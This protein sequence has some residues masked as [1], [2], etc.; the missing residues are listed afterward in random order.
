VTIT[1]ADGV[2]GAGGIRGLAIAGALLELQEGNDR[3]RISEW[4][5]L[6]GT[7]AG[8]IVA[9]YLAAGK[10][11]S[12]LVEL[13]PEIPRPDY[14]R[15]GMVMGGAWNLVRHRGLARG[16]RFQK[17][18]DGKLDGLEFG[19]LRVDGEYRL[20]MVAADITNRRIV[21]IPDDLGRYRRPGAKGP[22]DRDT[23]PVAFG[24]RM[25]MAIPYL[26]NPVELV[27]GDG[28]V[29]TIVD[30][31]VISGF[32]VWLFDV[33]HRDLLRPTFGV[34]IA[35]R[36]ARARRGIGW[37]VG[38]ARDIYSTGSGAWDAHFVADSS[39]LRTC[40]VPTGDIPG[41]RFNAPQADRDDLVRAGRDAM[42]E[43]LASYDPAKYKNSEGRRLATAAGA[44]TLA[45]LD[46]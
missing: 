27:D 46:D 23:C 21:K 3:V 8:A 26:V 31:G 6:G 29:C 12:Q 4:C 17:W 30:G 1:E 43:F 9:A 35:A 2:F 20:R 16:E 28:R 45:R 13:L 39:S 7:S 34:R 37:P 5:S 44:G 19:S 41:T 11:P 10:T 38:M 32:P 40:L 24:V 18:F 15:G 25:S 36:R 42:R 33:A 22:I 14:G